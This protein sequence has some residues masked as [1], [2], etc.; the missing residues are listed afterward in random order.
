MKTATTW[1]DV[2]DFAAWS[3]HFTGTQRVVYE[4]ANRY[5]K[6]KTQNVK[7]F[8]FDPTYFGFREIDFKLI[9]DRLEDTSDSKSTSPSRHPL[10]KVFQKAYKKAPP[11][12][13]RSISRQQKELFRQTY[14]AF[15]KYKATRH[16]NNTETNIPEKIGPQLFEKGDTVI[17]LGKPWDEGLFIECLKIHK[18]RGDFRLVHLIFDMIPCFLPHTF[19]RPLPVNYT[20]YMFD[21]LSI[22]DHVLSISESTAKDVRHFCDEQLLKIPPITV[23]RLGD[24][25]VDKQLARN[26]NGLDG[27][28]AKDFILCVGTIEV[29]KNHQLLY[30][31]YEEA[32]RRQLDLPKLIIVGSKG[33]YTQDFLYQVS[34]NPALKDKIIILSGM[35]DS[36]LAWLYTNCL[37]TIYPS[38]YEGWGLPV[39][40]SLGY[41]KVCI[42]SDSSSMPE[43]AGNLIDYFSPY[44][45]IACL[46]LMQKYL[47]VSVRKEKEREIVH[48]YKPSSWDSTFAQVREVVD[49]S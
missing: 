47:S 26:I 7:F 39:A 30:L 31:A 37:F 24:N 13:R 11:I 5:Y 19:G 22:T 2:T 45:T 23:I 14:A 25:A 21:A 20:R 4:I 40:E 15:Q 44:D 18:L 43:I 3:G 48:T 35:N 33:W 6:D 8:I 12:L 29:R 34:H 38:V 17:I 16:R 42:S 32:L 46:E 9:Q 27:V 41:G 49:K 10:V 28:P 1:I 36:Q